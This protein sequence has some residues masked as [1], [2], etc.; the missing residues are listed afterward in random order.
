MQNLKHFA[1]STILRRNFQLQRLHNK[2]GW[3]KE[4]TNDPRD[5]K[6]NVTQQ[7]HSTEVLG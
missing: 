2:M 7:K 4:R 3:F 6:S 5:G 1:M